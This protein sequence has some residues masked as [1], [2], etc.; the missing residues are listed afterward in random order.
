MIRQRY[1]AP[2]PCLPFY[3]E[4]QF[5]L[6]LNNTSDFYEAFPTAADLNGDGLQDIIVDRVKY[7]TYQT[8]PLDILLN[9]GKGGML[10]STSGV[11][12]GTVPHLQNRTQIVVA[13]YNGD[14]RLDIFAADHGYD[15]WP[16]PGYQNTLVLSTPDGRLVDATGNLPQQYDFTHSACAADIDA[17]GDIDL[18]TGNIWGQNSINP[19]IL[20]NDG[21]GRFIVAGQSLPPL[22]DLSHNGFTACL[23]C[24]VNND[25]SPD[26]ILGD[27]NEHSTATSRVLLNNG[28]GVFAH[29]PGAM[30]PKRSG[31]DV[32]HHIEPFDL[33]LDGHLDLLIEYEDP[34]AGSY[35]QALVNSGDG[36]F[37]DETAARI[38]PLDRPVWAPHFELRD[39]NR[40]GAMD[41][42][43]LPWDADKPDPILFLNDGHGHFRRKSFSLGLQGGD[44]Y[45]T[46]I[47]LEGDGGHDLLLTL[48]YPPD[49]VLA[50]RDMGCQP[51]APA[52]H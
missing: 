29:L 2:Q 27:A 22:T 32:S 42:L 30:P 11:F 36:T 40:D 44:L 39:V 47:D 17:D 5:L 33:N 51:T 28:A 3:G 52:T 43:A 45:Y 38:E 1:H 9:D 48:N 8:F 20:L 13:D 25:G 50:I 10:L 31:A 46:F 12:S 16:F 21:S 18:Y 23:F 24:D 35:I 34:Q 14:H 6:Q 15:E 4:R 19:Q 49:Y 37:R 41:L 7:L 26:L